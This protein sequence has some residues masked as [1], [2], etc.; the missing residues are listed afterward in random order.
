MIHP[1]NIRVERDVIRFEAPEVRRFSTVPATM[2]VDTN[3]F[4]IRAGIRPREW[5]EIAS[6]DEVVIPAH[7]R[8]VRLFDEERDAATCARFLH[9]VTYEFL[10]QIRDENGRGSW[11]TD[12]VDCTIE[13]TE[14]GDDAFA[15][16]I[17]EHLR[18]LPMFHRCTINGVERFTKG[19]SNLPFARALAIAGS[20]IAVVALIVV[21][22]FAID[23]AVD[24]NP[25]WRRAF[26]AALALATAGAT[27]AFIVYERRRGNAG[28]RS[29]VFVAAIATLVL[30]QLLSE[31]FAA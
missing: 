17:A 15:A 4:I 24:R 14:I 30:L 8:F 13:F 7:L 18:K 16:A 27:V 20:I 9:H 10:Q 26:L 3:G 5:D 31:V 22:L 23:A 29:I 1:L 19:T 6:E 12:R 21:P 11:F 25:A 28:M 2:L